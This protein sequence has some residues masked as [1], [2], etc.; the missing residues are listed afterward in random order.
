MWARGSAPWACLMWEG[1]RLRSSEPGGGHLLLPVPSHVCPSH[2]QGCG[3]T[4]PRALVGAQVRASLE[5]QGD[6]FGAWLAGTAALQSCLSGAVPGPGEA[7][8]PSP[9]RPPPPPSRSL[10]SGCRSLGCPPDLAS[11]RLENRDKT[12]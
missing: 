2:W 8:A 6:G 5:L 3:P 9:V 12:K 11:V 4:P 1:W 7:R 10:G